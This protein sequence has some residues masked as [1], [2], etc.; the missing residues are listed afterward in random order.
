MSEESQ[1]A[2]VDTGEQIDFT[3]I[4]NKERLKVKFPSSST[5]GSLK[6][7]IQTL[8]GLPSGMQKLVYKGNPTSHSF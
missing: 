8:T 6:E 2:S 7:H 5:I 4:F 3:I 1:T